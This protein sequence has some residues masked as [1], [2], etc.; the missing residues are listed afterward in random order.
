MDILEI[1][2]RA[3]IATGAVIALTRIN[4]LRSFSKMSGFDFA[5]TVAKGSILA[6]AM[7]AGSWNRFWVIL[8]ALLALFL[9][10]GIISRLRER[11]GR[12]EGAVDNTPLLLMRNGE[13]L[14]ENLKRGQVSRS[15]VI[16]KLREANALRL[17]QV[18]AVVLEATGDVSV[19]HGPEECD[20]LLLEGVAR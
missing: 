20:D 3:A 19:L 5:L 11:F 1:L 17:D 18:R 7:M 13:F 16:G 8:A 12:M 4:G 9:V 10:Q 6:S 14:D 15:D 2:L